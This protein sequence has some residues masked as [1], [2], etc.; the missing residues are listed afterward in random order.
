MKTLEVAEQYF[1][2]KRLAPKTKYG[3]EIFFKQLASFTEE[4][5]DNA[6]TIT[7]YLR[8]IE[9]IK[10]YKDS[11]IFG[12]YSKLRMIYKFMQKYLDY[13][14]N[15]L[16]KVEVPKVKKQAHRLFSPQEI[17]EIFKAC[18][19]QYE[20]AL[21]VTLVD[22]TC[23][24]GELKDLKLENVDNNCIHVPTGKTGQHTYRLDPR[25]CDMLR[26]IA[27]ESG[28]IFRT[29]NMKLST[30]EGIKKRFNHIIARTSIKGSKLGPHTLR[31]SGASMI[32]QETGSALAV[33]AAL[34]HANINT[35]MIYVHEVEDKLQQKISPLKLVN[36]QLFSRN[37]NFKQAALLSSSNGKQ[38][39]TNLP[40]SATVTNTLDTLIESSFALIPDGTTIRPNLKTEDIR[41]LRRALICLSQFG[42]VITDSKEA[43]ILFNRITRRTG[44]ITNDQPIKSEITDNQYI[45]K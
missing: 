21:I 34:Q 29:P 10:H 36:D 27:Q 30:T 25:V 9:E 37:S 40:I 4:M 44:T 32:A 45:I 13:D 23:R 14:K 11:T 1:I 43:R 28:Y 39:N 6:I 2:I 16:L 18:K 31:H 22:S 7:K 3:F 26:A 42:Q 15:P 41:L 20:T 5:P 33:K 12:H 35:S 19:T 38:I 8:Y 17:N 24:I